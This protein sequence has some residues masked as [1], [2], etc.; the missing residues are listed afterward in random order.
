MM[1][2]VVIIIIVVFVVVVAVRIAIRPLAHGPVRHGHVVVVVVV[3]SF[4]LRIIHKVHSTYNARSDN[5]RRIGTSSYEK[6]IAI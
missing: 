5:K 1:E 2:V 4:S 6:A 3:F